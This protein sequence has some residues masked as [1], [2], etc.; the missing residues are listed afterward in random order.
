MKP[1]VVRNS[2][3]R[4]SSETGQLLEG[5]ILEKLA[6]IGKISRSDANL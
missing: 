4:Y 2:N 6:D 1:G 5:Q 3:A